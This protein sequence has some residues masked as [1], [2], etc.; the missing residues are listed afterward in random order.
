MNLQA[1]SQTDSSIT[2]QWSNSRA[3]VGSYRVKYS[4][5]SGASHG[6]E[7][8]PQGLEGTTRVTLTGMVTTLQWFPVNGATVSCLFNPSVLQG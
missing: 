1:V 6:E 4:P 8:F 7:L 5:F 3:T 2:L